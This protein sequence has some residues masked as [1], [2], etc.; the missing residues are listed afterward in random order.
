MSSIRS[1]RHFPRVVSL[2]YNSQ[3]LKCTDLNKRQANLDKMLFGNSKMLKNSFDHILAS[4]DLSRLFVASLN[5]KK[6]TRLS[7]YKKVYFGPTLKLSYLFNDSSI[8]TFSTF[9]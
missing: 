8:K 4:S 6:N 9:S 7:F 5:L 2:P 3:N 1:A